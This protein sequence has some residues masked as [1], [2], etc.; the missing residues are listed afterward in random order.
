[1]GICRFF[2]AQNLPQNKFCYSS[3]KPE[4]QFPKNAIFQRNFKKTKK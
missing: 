4:M 3:N 1:M 2:V